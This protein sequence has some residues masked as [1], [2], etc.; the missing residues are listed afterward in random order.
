MSNQEGK[1]GL[2]GGFAVGGYNT[3]KAD[4]KCRSTSA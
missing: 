1:K 2:K 4:E 3:N